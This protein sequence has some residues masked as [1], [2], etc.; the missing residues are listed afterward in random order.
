[1][2]Q[3]LYQPIRVNPEQRAII[4]HLRAH[5]L[6]VVSAGAGAGKTYTTVAAIIELIGQRE[7]S[8]DQF[9]LITFTNHAADHLR[10]AL[11]KALS[12]QVTLAEGDAARRMYWLAQREGLSCA[13]IG[14]IHGFCKQI[15]SLYGYGAGVAR[16]ASIS[17]AGYVRKQ[18][19]EQ[20]VEEWLQRSP[21]TPMA[22]RVRDAD[23]PEYKMCKLLG[24]MLEKARNQGTSAQ[25]ILEATQQQSEEPGKAARLELA[26]LLALA[27]RRYRIA[28]QDAQQL[29]AAALLEKT[30][31][32][33]QSASGAQVVAALTERFRFLLIDEFQDTT[34]TQA[35][36]V[37]I[38]AGN[39]KVL[40]VGDKKQSIYAFAGA[41]VALLTSFAQRHNTSCL[42][43]R[44][45]GRPTRPLLD[46]QNA[47]FEKMREDFPELDD[48]LLPNERNHP[49]RDRLP[50]I[51]VVLEPAH[52]PTAVADVTAKINNMFGLEMDR[53][54]DEGPRTIR[55]ADIAILVRTNEEV[56]NWG[57]YLRDAGI[58][59]RTDTGFSYLRQ[60]EVIATYRFLQ[61]LA[62]FPDDVA[63][64]E[65]LLTPHF[66]G[67]DLR[68]EESHILTYGA[69]RGK[70]LTD[71]YERLYPQHAQQVRQ[72]LRQS[73]IA[74]V[75]QLLGLI[76]REFDLKARFRQEADEDAAVNLD[77]LRDYAR[78]RFN[79]DQALTLR[80][81]LEMLHRDI[82][83]KEGPRDPAE[84][85]GEA[86]GQVTVMSVHRSKGLEFPV[87]I[88]PGLE[89]DRRSKRPPDHIVDPEL[90]LE[91][92]VKELG[93]L[94]SPAFQ[95]RWQDAQARILAEEMR[96]FYVA[97]TRA[98]HMV[99]MFGVRQE[100]PA[101]TDAQ[102]WQAQVLKAYDDMKRYGATFTAV[103][104]SDE[105]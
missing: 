87:V 19:I 51:A 7:A 11:H 40:V 55:P 45:S 30:L 52:I 50:P 79:S 25:V 3:P 35:A 23:Y 60:P 93:V 69:Q 90:G 70:P 20:L 68:A 64:A 73:R 18:V 27:E 71:A 28:C 34:A 95:A 31:D 49:A 9:I 44:M 54:P 80:T 84:Q 39:M 104:D 99:C 53:P 12:N 81:F 21:S 15:L 56:R 38:L 26:S 36:I 2:S 17:F 89:K 61:L 6:T 22:D 77:R 42:P 91:V 33:L 13:F 58:P 85:D 72:L 103:S 82:M 37:D 41:D 97:V 47:L 92:N 32:L 10:Q 66:K 14:T 98:R 76:E 24:Q 75:P 43:L 59:V 86:D 57:Q 88:I 101:S 67:I 29:D 16:E 78:N 65:A 4:D 63:L 48:P 94:P 102:S 5:P 8:A 105:D 62:R 46:A 74:T 1:M 96:L 100:E 83:N